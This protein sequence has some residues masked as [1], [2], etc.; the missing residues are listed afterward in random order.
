MIK[1]WV[2]SLICLTIS[3]TRLW[4][5]IA[6]SISVACSADSATQAVLPF[7]LNVQRHDPG[8]WKATLP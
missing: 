7:T 1:V 8:A 2:I 6:C 3:S 4:F 5:S